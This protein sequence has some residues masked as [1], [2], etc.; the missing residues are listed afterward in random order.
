MPDGG[1]TEFPFE[2]TDLHSGKR[3]RPLPADCSAYSVRFGP[4]ERLI[5][6]EERV[7]R[8]LDMSSGKQLSKVE[9][10]PDTDELITSADATTAVEVFRIGIRVRIVHRD[11]STGRRVGSWAFQFDDP[12][13]LS[14]SRTGLPWL[15]PDGR[16]FVFSLP[17]A[18]EIYRNAYQSGILHTRTGRLISSW[19]DDSYCSCATLSPDGRAFCTRADREINI[20]EVATGRLRQRIPAARGL[21][22]L[23]FS[24]DGR[25]LAVATRPRPIEVYDLYAEYSRGSWDPAKRDQ[26]WATLAQ[27]DAVAAF[28]IIGHLR[29]NPMEAVAFLRQQ[30]K[31]PTGPSRIGW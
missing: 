26:H 23:G 27:P 14:E 9:K 5:V 13:T 31:M 1:R 30:M 3:T 10:S 16:Y 25:L 17:R 18:H 7:V 29:A 21:S 2:L 24:A 11:L 12:T 28:A 8:V 19:L 15:S 20:R 6:F 22:A 4:G